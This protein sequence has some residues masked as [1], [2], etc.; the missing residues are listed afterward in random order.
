MGLI[1]QIVDEYVKV[2]PNHVKQL[3]RAFEGK[4]IIYC[5]GGGVNN[6]LYI[7]FDPYFNDL[8][9]LDANMLDV[10]TVVNSIEDDLYPIL[11]TAYGLSIELDGRDKDV[12]KLTPFSNTFDKAKIH[13]SEG[14]PERNDDM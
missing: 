11:S 9:L 4:N 6:N 7:G 2:N 8:R 10:D 5:G 12:I 13:A 3:Y 14:V 1:M